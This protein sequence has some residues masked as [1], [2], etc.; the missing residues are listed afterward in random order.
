M[1]YVDSLSECARIT[2]FTM[3]QSYFANT[4]TARGEAWR[5][6]ER[7]LIDTRNGRRLHHYRMRQNIVDGV[8]SY[9]VILYRT[10]MARFYAP[11]A[12]GVECRL[13]MGDSR[14]TSTQFMHSVLRTGPISYE[15]GRIVPIYPRDF[16]TDGNAS[17]SLRLY[18]KGDT[19]DFE[20]SKHTPHF[21]RRSN[22]A[23]RMAR[24]DTLKHLDNFVLMAQMRLPEYE[25]NVQLSERYGS[26]FGGDPVSRSDTVSMQRLLSNNPD[27]D[28]VNAFFDLG[29]SVFNVLASKRAF[30]QEDM[31]LASR[32]SYRSGAVS[33]YEMLK[34]KVTADDFKK[35]LVNKLK[36]ALNLNVRSDKIEIP[37]FVV[38]K[39]Y[40]RTAIVL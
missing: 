39:D 16:M 4:P 12:N 1:S 21:I 32:Y 22:K 25:A 36:Q 5:T 8:A 27:A 9:D 29:Q 30:E 7:P 17:F 20:R 35:S 28:A 2:N 31:T 34:N 11:D 6:D 3:A 18:V 33:P 10:V 13:Y 24:A 38:E 37:Q 26:A 14:Q 15:D 19:I 40:P 23:D